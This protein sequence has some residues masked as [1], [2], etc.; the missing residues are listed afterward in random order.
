MITPGSGK[1]FQT[2]VRERRNLSIEYRFRQKSGDYR[3]MLDRSVV[4]ANE[5]VNWKRWWAFSY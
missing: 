5:R 2:A 1:S 3:W 4:T